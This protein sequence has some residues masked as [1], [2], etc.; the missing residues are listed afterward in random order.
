MTTTRFAAAV[1]A[2][3]LTL[4]ACGDDEDATT[5]AEDASDVDEPGTNDEGGLAVE[6]VE[7]Y[8]AVLA[9]LDEAAGE[10]FSGLDDSATEEDYDRVQLQF[11]QDHR[12]D[13]ERLVAAA[14][15]EI[16][17]DLETVVDGVLAGPTSPETP[18]AEERVNEFDQTNCR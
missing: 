13:F 3:L 14:P 5:P 17:E 18:E 10:A 1:L 6:G 2:A 8:C 16:A 4:T 11:T 9:E 15:E 7:E 12:E